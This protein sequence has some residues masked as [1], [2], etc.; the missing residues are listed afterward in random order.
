MQLLA[1]ATGVAV[2]SIDADDLTA[3]AKA[4][5]AHWKQA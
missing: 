4:F 1:L 3:S 2:R 5:W